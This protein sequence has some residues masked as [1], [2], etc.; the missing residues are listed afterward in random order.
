FRKS[1]FDFGALVRTVLRSNLFFSAQAYRT[2]VKS[3]VDFA[4]GI[5][6]GLEGRI[7]TTALAGELDKMGQSVFYPPA[8]KG[9]DGG[10]AWSNGQSFLFRQNLGLSLASTEDVRF[11]R[12]CDP[13]ALAR[14]YG[15]KG[16][17]ELVEFFLN[18]FLQG[19]VSDEARRKL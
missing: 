12:R 9:W 18:L 5:A 8:V 16:D 2:R 14:K 6:R 11:G 1:G 3:P 13:A 4:L 19:D 17:R 7:G 15:K 10:P